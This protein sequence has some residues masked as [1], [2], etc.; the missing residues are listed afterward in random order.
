M[1]LE[2]QLCL[3]GFGYFK[4]TKISKIIITFYDIKFHFNHKIFV[5][6][7]FSL[8]SKLKI[9]QKSQK[10]KLITLLVVLSEAL[11]ALSPSHSV[12]PKIKMCNIST[13]Q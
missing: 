10:T 6:I 5:K 13:L 7:T 8:F 9:T 2:I 1:F 12:H 11:A 3:S 4:I